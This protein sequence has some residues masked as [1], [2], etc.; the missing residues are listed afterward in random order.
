MSVKRSGTLK[1]TR[2]PERDDGGAKGVQSY[3]KG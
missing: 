3:R 2:S 1:G